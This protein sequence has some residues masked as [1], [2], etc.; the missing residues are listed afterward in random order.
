MR[1]LIFIKGLGLGGAEHQVVQ[2]ARFMRSRGYHV[3]V[4]YL[5]PH[6]ADLESALQALG[7]SVNCVGKGPGPWWLNYPWRTW[8]ELSQYKPQLVHAHLPIPGVICRFFKLFFKYR[9]LYTEHN[10]WERLHLL[11]RVVHRATWVF[12]DIAISCSQAVADSVPRRSIAINNAIDP[13]VPDRALTSMRLSLGLPVASKVWLCVA[14]FKVQKNHMLLLRAFDS[15]V[16]YNN[17]SDWHLVLVGQDVTELAKCKLLVNSLSS[18]P[19]IKFAGKRPEAASWMSEADAFVL[20]SNEE[21]LP[22]ALLEAMRA[23]LPVVV[24]DAGGMPSVV[25]PNT[26]RVVPR[27][28]EGALLQAMR[29]ISSDLDLRQKMGAAAKARFREC[30]TEDAMLNSLE[31]LYKSV[32]KPSSVY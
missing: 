17:L 27:N 18:A 29:E 14:N 22:L 26:G 10:V 16:R 6:A 20:S 19:R 7:V 5:L 2:I 8:L 13:T 21:G 24:T 25:T 9:L 32:L 28:D 15:L 3:R 12:D 31:R 1:L 23:G 11:S 4:F 30:Y